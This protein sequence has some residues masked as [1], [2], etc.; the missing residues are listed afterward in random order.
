[1][2][3]GS[4]VD[5][6]ETGAETGQVDV[7]RQR[8][9]AA[10][11]A[12]GYRTQATNFEAEAGL[13]KARASSAGTAGFL[14]AGGTLLSGVGSIGGKWSALT[15]PTPTTPASASQEDLL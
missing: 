13:E 2:N 14:K 15:N 8:Q 3:T 5:V 7:E 6:Q 1:M 4:A 12:Y 10:L 11:R 9:E